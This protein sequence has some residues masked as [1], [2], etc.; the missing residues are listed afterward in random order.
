M[1]IALARSVATQNTYMWPERIAL[2][3]TGFAPKEQRSLRGG[4]EASS[5]Q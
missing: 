2:S 4:A 3:L 5:P 1:T